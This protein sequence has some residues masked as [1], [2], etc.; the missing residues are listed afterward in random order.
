MI[1]EDDMG[2]QK[3]NVPVSRSADRI[4][5]IASQAVYDA[6]RWMG[7]GA[8]EEATE[9][10]YSSSLSDKIEVIRE[11][12]DSFFEQEYESQKDMAF[13]SK[14]RNAI[15]ELVARKMS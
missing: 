15:I 2:P 11:N 3:K 12:I 9:E 10:F 13:I 14:H 5:E 8:D 6:D 4:E 7:D 1:D